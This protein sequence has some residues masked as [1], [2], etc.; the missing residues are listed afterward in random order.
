MRKRLALSASLGTVLLSTAVLGACPGTGAHPKTNNA[1]TSC[2]DLS[3]VPQISGNIVAT[4]PLPAAKTATPIDLDD[5]PYTGP[6]VGLTKPE[7]GV[8]PTPTVGYHW[9]LD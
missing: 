5:K 9:S 1:L 2:L 8:K 7:P 6:K 4:Q 3:T